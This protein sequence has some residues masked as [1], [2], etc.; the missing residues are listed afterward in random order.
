VDC[1]VCDKKLRRE[2]YEGVPIHRCDD[3]YGVFAEERRIRQIKNLRK[4]SPSDLERE[5]ESEARPDAEGRLRCP[6]CLAIYMTKEDIELD[7]EDRPDSFTI[8]ICHECDSIWFDGGELARVQLDFE[9][10]AQAVEAWRLV[11]LAGQRT[12]DEETE[13]QERIAEAPAP[14]NLPF[15][16]PKWAIVIGGVLGILAFCLLLYLFNEYVN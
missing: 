2:Q 13:L 14:S 1:P 3:C 16:L 4:Q 15:A 5:A 10:S 12:P 9:Q 8:D 11:K 6:K 7:G